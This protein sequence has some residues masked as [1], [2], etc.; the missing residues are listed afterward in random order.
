[1]VVE[2]A[3]NVA[4]K[5]ETASS[6]SARIE[7]GGFQGVLSRTGTIESLVQA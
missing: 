5:P 2:P 4:G 6:D 3:P 7:T 1:M